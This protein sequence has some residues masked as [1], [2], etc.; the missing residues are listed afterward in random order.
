MLLSAL[1]ALPFNEQLAYAVQRAKR[2]RKGIKR[3]FE[4]LF[5]PRPLKEVRRVFAVAEEKY[6]P[7]VYFGSAIW[8]RATEKG[9]R[10]VDN[11][12]DDWSK[13]VTGGVEVHDIVGDHGSIL[14][15]P[16]VSYLAESL[17]LCLNQAEPER[18][19]PE[20]EEQIS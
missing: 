2:I 16:D 14:K 8:F 19:E 11:P 12:T 20:L 9:L 10:G 13:W 4:A 6:K 7:Q 3:R 1:R 18:A 15:E 17:R 5:L